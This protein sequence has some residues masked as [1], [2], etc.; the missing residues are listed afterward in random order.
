[1]AKKLIR[2]IRNQKG[3]LDAIHPIVGDESGTADFLGK[4]IKT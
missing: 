3:K 2:V 4:S 1:M